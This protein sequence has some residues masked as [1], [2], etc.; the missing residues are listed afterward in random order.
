[1][2]LLPFAKSKSGTIGTE[3]ELQIVH[4]KT[5]DLASYAKELIRQ[6]R[7]ARFHAQVKP[8]I[9]QGMLEINSNVHV[10]PQKLHNEL[11]SL[12]LHLQNLA[13]QYSVH[14]CGGGTHPFQKWQ[15]Q[16]VF[17]SSRYKKIKRHF[18]FFCHRATL[19]GQH[20]HIGCANGDD[21]IYLINALARYVPQFIAL[22]ASSPF[23]QSIDT[24]MDSSRAALFAGFPMYG[25]GPYF[26]DYQEF[27][28]YFYQMRDWGIIETMKDLY[29]DIRP[30]PEFGTVEIRVCDTP[31]TI[32]KAV[33]IVAYVQALCLYLL[34]KKPVALS[35]SMHQVYEYNRFE[36][37]R[38]GYNGNILLPETNKYISIADDII[39]TLDV[40]AAYAKRNKSEMYIEWLKEE[41]LS[42]NND[43]A[44]LRS[45]RKKNRSFAEIV[46]NQGQ[47]QNL[48]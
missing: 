21:A 46:Q 26:K 32:K 43:T 27:S 19:F 12:Q 40:I 24:G 7:N 31:L 39:N 42:K 18:R 44:Y 37:I 4:A 28:E 13:L 3:L 17:P 47:V 48:L 35:K 11:L 14:F 36:G 41:V 30:K 23:Y 5:Y 22:S 1:M 9:T 8:E 45:L 15:N 38:Y 29:W 16:R 2:S 34:E 25:K 6:A 10:Y 33:A 20:I